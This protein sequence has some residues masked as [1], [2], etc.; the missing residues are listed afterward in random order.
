VRNTPTACGPG[1][2]GYVVRA[3][4]RRGRP[5]RASVRLGARVRIA[6]RVL[7][8]GAPIAGAQVRIV[9]RLERRAARPGLLPAVLVTG[10]DGRF[11]HRLRAR[12]AARL[13]VG[14]RAGS[15]TALTCSRALRLR[16]RASATLRASRQIVAGAARVIFRGRLRGGHIPATGKLVVLQGYDRGAW[17]TFATARSDRRGR[18][19]AGY[20]FRGRP[21]TYRVRARIP[22]DAAYPFAA[23]RSHAVTVRVL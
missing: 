9:R 10:R 15:D 1:A 3:G 5:R 20:R 4:F 21:G 12:A 2:A 17:R 13:R 8:N 16:T 22:V 19:H 23:G 18:F 14:I 7:A 6:G 11:R